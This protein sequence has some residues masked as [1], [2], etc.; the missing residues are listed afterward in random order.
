MNEDTYNSLYSLTD[1]EI[2]ELYSIYEY[3]LY[4]SNSAGF[5][6]EI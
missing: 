2:S 1:E 3:D 6:D 5:V 4:V